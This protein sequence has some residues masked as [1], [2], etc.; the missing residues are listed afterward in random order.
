[1]HGKSRGVRMVL[2]SVGLL[3]GL[4]LLAGGLYGV[5]ALGGIQDGELKPWAWIAV[6]GVG[7]VF[8]HMQVLG[9]AAMITLVLDEET[10]R[11]GKTSISKETEKT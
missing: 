1:M 2:G 11:R 7:T 6:A 4:A 5:F 10:A 8:I 3:T 9:A